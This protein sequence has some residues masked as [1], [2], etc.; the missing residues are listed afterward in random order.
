[1]NTY[2]FIIKLESFYFI[3]AIRKISWAVTFEQRP[4]GG[5]GACAEIPEKGHRQMEGWS[6]ETMAGARPRP[7][8]PGPC[9]CCGVMGAEG[10]E[11]LKKALFSYFRKVEDFS[12]SVHSKLLISIFRRRSLA[13]NFRDRAITKR[14][15][16]SSQSVGQWRPREL[17][18]NSP[19]RPLSSAFCPLYKVP[20]GCLGVP[21]DPGSQLSQN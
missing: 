11:V 1:M 9:G 19:P 15:T 18:A 21:S 10:Q 8:A 5:A 20:E 13:R 14:L 17:G 7:G 2:V 6:A 16:S 4:G 12:N 3:K